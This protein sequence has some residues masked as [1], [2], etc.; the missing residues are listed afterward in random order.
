MIAYMITLALLSKAAAVCDPGVY[1]RNG[2]LYTLWGP[3]S[4]L[5]WLGGCLEGNIFPATLNDTFPTNQLLRGS[6]GNELYQLRECAPED[7]HKCIYSGTL[8]S[9]SEEGQFFS[10]SY[11]LLATKLS[12][13]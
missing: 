4:D 5:S 9:T 10:R 13:P 3:L 1:T 12:I 2:T 11:F 6:L 8:A 7:V